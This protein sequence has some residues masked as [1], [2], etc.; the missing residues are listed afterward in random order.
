MYNLKM[1]IVK[2]RNM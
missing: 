1:T 2:R